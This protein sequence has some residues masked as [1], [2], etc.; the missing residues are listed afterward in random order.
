MQ[1]KRW[2]YKFTLQAIKTCK[3]IIIFNYG[4]VLAFNFR[5]DCTS[6]TCWLLF[7]TQ[8]I[9]LQIDLANVIIYFTIHFAIQRLPYNLISSSLFSSGSLLHGYVFTFFLKSEW[10][11]KMLFDRPGVAGAVLQ[12]ASSFIN[13]VSQWSFS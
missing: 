5:C 7:Y 3:F 4:M 2:D 13:S 8:F 6:I 10:V 9:N 1:D 11:V 12:T